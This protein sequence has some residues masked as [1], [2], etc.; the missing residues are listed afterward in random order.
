MKILLRHLSQKH[1]LLLAL[2]LIQGLEAFAVS[3]EDDLK[4]VQREKQAHG[5]HVL[6]M[7]V[8]MMKQS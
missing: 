4:G 8:E 1:S 7:L 2:I 3:L 6:N 5:E